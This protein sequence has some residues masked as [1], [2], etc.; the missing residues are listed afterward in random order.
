MMHY[1]T[2]FQLGPLGVGVGV[3]FVLLAFPLRT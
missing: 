3:G 1:C 2:G